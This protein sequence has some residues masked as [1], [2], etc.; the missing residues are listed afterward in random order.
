MKASLTIVADWFRWSLALF[1]V[2]AAAL[3]VGSVL[4]GLAAVVWVNVWQRVSFAWSDAVRFVLSFGLA[5]AV[6]CAAFDWL[7]EWGARS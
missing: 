3:L 6:V 1:V 2:T 5:L 4:L 7:R